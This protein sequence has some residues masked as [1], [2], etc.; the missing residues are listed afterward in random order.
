[1]KTGIESACRLARPIEQIL[2]QDMKQTDLSKRTTLST[3]VETP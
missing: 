1:M 3:T 2:E